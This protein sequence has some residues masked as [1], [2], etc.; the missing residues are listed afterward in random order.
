MLPNIAYVGGQAELAYWL[1]LR[2][3]FQA[4]GVFFP[5]VLPRVQALAVP[6][7]VSHKL[8]ELGCTLA[9]VLRSPAQMLAEE[10][11]HW[12][13]GDAFAT[14][15]TQQAQLMAALEALSASTDETLRKH[16]RAQQAR[17]ARFWQRLDHKLNKAAVQR[18]PARYEAQKRLQR[19]VQPHGLVQ[20]RV[21]G[22]SALGPDPAATWQRLMAVVPPLADEIV[23]WGI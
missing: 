4:L 6:A 2:P 11:A 7:A 12:R 1:Q 20:E 19:L 10:A 3:V 16:V 5:V 14:L 17:Q 18:H 8:D 15:M 13:D 22:L 9:E 23:V 21:W